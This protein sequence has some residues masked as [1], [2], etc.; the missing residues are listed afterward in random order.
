LAGD[1]AHV[2]VRQQHVTSLNAGTIIALQRVVSAI[3]RNRRAL[4]TMIAGIGIGTVGLGVLALSNSPLDGAFGHD[5]ALGGGDNRLSQA[6]LLG[7]NHRPE[8]KNG[9]Y[10]GYAFL[11]G[12]VGSSMGGFAGA[13]LYEILADQ[14]HAPRASWLVFVGVGIVTVLGLVLYDRLLTPR[15]PESSVG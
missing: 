11:D 13:G 2:Q 4:P 3:V 10:M 1:R 6:H 15:N 7:G 12:V 9:V 14:M 8:D 5:R